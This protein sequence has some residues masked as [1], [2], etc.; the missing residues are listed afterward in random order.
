MRENLFTRDAPIGGATEQCRPER[1]SIASPQPDLEAVGNIFKNDNCL[2]LLNKIV[3]AVLTTHC[4]H[5]HQNLRHDDASVEQY[6]RADNNVYR[7]TSAF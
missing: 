3:M 6:Q 4:M 5:I 2:Y 1:A 7:W